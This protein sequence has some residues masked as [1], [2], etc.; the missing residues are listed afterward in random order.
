MKGLYM[1]NGVY[2][3]RPPVESG[4][5]LP[6]F[7]LKTK[8]EG[9]AIEKVLAYRHEVM[10][11]RE[12]GGGLWD[13]AVEGYLKMKREEGLHTVLSSHS[14]R[15]TLGVVGV[16][17]GKPR[18]RS[19]NSQMVADL[20]V[21]LRGRDKQSGR[22]SGKLSE[23]SVASYLRVFKAFCG[24]L[25]KEEVLASHPMEG[26][27]HPKAGRTRREEFYTV[28]ERVRVLESCEGDDLRMIL[29]LGFLG[30]MRIGEI[31]A[32]TWGWIWIDG[33]N[34]RGAIT[35]QRTKFG[36]GEGM[37]FAPKG[38]VAREIPLHPMLLEALR[39]RQARGFGEGFLVR[40]EN[41]KWKLPPGY[42]YDPKKSMVSLFKKNGL[43][44]TGYHRLR[45]SFATHLILNGVTLSEVASL[46]G[47][48][49]MVVQKHYAGFLP[50]T[51]ASVRGLTLD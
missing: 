16:E 25:V 7:S 37:V 39:D 24:W 33:E 18:P 5:S 44:W 45:H 32:A 35:V 34:E 15:V 23:N 42:R 8:K 31:L 47:D 36:D 41:D 20:I 22:G 6:R 29:L 46:L 43:E 26:R 21:S 11:A 9:V 13:E 1:R 17:L 40:P 48:E 10:M 2:W 51:D 19:I 50:G 27:R 30:G 38:K 49:I 4:K 28:E 14:A 3:Y 12:F